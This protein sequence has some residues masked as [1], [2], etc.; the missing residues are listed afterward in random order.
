METIVFLS[1]L[2]C[3]I[4]DMVLQVVEKYGRLEIKGQN[5]SKKTLKTG[6]KATVDCPTY[7][8]KFLRGDLT[9]EEIVSLFNGLLEGKATFSE[10]IQ[11]SSCIK[12]IKDVQRQFI[13]CTG[14]DN[15]E[16]VTKR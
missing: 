9:K 6:L 16:E 8:F 2:P 10:A 13:T 7:N 14:C 11:E 3:V 5:A 12:E 4:Y 15:W 1:A